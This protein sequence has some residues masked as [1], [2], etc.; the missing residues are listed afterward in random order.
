MPRDYK[1]YLDDILQAIAKVREYNAG[2]SSARLA[3]DTKTFDAVIRNL[4]VIGEAANGVSE[5]IRL[6]HPEVDWKRFA[7]LRD[8]LIHQ[9][10]GVNAQ[11]NWDIIQN[12]L[13]A[14]EKQIRTILKS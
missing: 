5:V 8:V 13:P 1:V 11:I 6:Q 14:L 7:G 2:F 10:F 9:Y 12:K 4:E 3:G